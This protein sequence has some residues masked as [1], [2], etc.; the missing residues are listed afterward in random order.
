M[1]SNPATEEELARAK[2]T[3]LNS[4]IFNYASKGQ[5][6]G[7]QMLY[8]YYGLPVDFLEKY[9]DNIEKVT[10]GDVARVARDYLQ[11]DRATLLV[12]G[13][14]KDFD[15]PMSSFGEVTE[16]DI[17][18]P[19]P[20]DPT[21]AVSVSAEGEA[22]GRNV[23]DRMVAALGGADPSA[24][25]SLRTRTS[26]DVNMQGQAMTLVQ[27]LTLVYPQDVYTT[28]QTPVGLQEVVITGGEG[29]V[30]MG[31]QSQPLPPSQV[32]SQLKDLSRQL[33]ALVREHASDSIGASL[34]GTEEVDGVA[35]DVILVSTEVFATRLWVDA[36]GLVVK[37]S[38]Q[39]TH[40]ATGAPG[41]FVIRFS[42]YREVAGYLF[43]YGRE[44][45]IDGVDFA[46]ATVEL[47]EF[48]PPV[49]MSLFEQPSE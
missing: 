18:I 39:G 33:F 37:Q 34:I 29:F 38:H 26:L 28:I 44:T 15:R 5:V 35:T 20:P 40:P 4:F 22:A 30:R 12:V 45:K 21:A 8:A 43:P 23:F 14:S 25:Q 49:D 24:I 36:G 46:T 10:T 11:P 1:V 27:T 41:E 13:R 7:Q 17:S 6:L 48:N 2:D 19:A 32:E 16:L 31:E 47:V 9:R 3:I 42:D